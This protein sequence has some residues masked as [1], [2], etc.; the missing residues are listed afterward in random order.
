MYEY[1]YLHP[2]EV[3]VGVCCMCLNEKLLILASKQGQ[4]LSKSTF[5]NLSFTQRNKKKKNKNKRNIKRKKNKNKYPPIITLRKI[6]HLTKHSFLHPFEFRHRQPPADIYDTDDSDDDD[7]ST[8]I[9]SEED[10]FISIKFENNGAASWEKGNI[11][12]V[13]LEECNNSWN[14][15]KDANKGP[16]SLVE[17]AKSRVFSLRWRKR[18]GNLFQVIRW[19]RSSRWSVCHVG[20]KLEGV[21]VRNGW[22]RN[23]TKRRPN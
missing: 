19:K 2:E 8:S 9:N 5:R 3:A 14:D 16:T 1:C 23:L 21:K 11:S 18:I 13:S 7:D 10:S 22:M 4:L 6:F 20:A 12:K 15:R 17:H